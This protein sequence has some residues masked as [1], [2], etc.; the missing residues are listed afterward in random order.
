MK[1]WI[2]AAAVML[3]AACAKEVPPPAPT[4]IVESKVVFLE[5]DGKTPRAAPKVLATTLSGACDT[6]IR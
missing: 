6:S 2:V 5:R 3:L 1:G 4:L